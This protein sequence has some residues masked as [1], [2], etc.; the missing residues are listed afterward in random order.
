MT[1]SRLSNQRPVVTFILPA[2]PE[3]PRTGGEIYNRC[4]IGGLRG[5]GVNVRVLALDKLVG[6][7]ALHASGARPGITSAI[8][9]ALDAWHVQQSENPNPGTIVFDSWL[10]RFIWP[11]M[12]RERLRGRFRIVSF[13]QLCYWDTWHSVPHRLWH[14]LLTWA[15]LAPAHCHIGVSHAVLRADLGPF[16][17]AQ[18]S[19]VIYPGCDYAGGDIPQADCSRMPAEILSVGNYA[20][21]KGF[22]ILI[23]ALA[24]VFRRCPE[25]NGQLCLR[26]VGNR[27]FDP[28]YLARL[29]RLIAENDLGDSVIVDG[30]KNRDEVS[31]LFSKSQIFA[32]ASES[33]GLGMVVLEAML[34][35]LPALL[36]DFMTAREILGPNRECGYVV[37]RR[38]P[39]AFAAAL[40]DYF[41]DRDR[42][43]MGCSICARARTLAHSW[44]DVAGGFLEILWRES[45]P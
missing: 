7:Q 32:F 25:L 16:H 8:R 10:Y 43:S 6:E 30:W 20:P 17:S 38:D 37:D 2:F 39:D 41:T 27:D 40:I 13:S 45:R 14:R 23:E 3:Q 42:S 21:R 26:L 19:E 24:C 29:E 36:G 22:H 12:F 18:T 5:R 4:V 33:E 35:G 11:I 44:D 1:G 34:H 31:R 15:A 28:A 9:Q